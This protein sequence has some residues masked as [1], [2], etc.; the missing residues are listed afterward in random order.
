MLTDVCNTILKQQSSAILKRDKESSYQLVKENNFFKKIIT[1]QIFDL[2]KS[3][4]TLNIS[5][6]SRKKQIIC[7]K[8]VLSF[9]FHLKIREFE[10][11]IKFTV[12]YLLFIGRYMYSLL[13]M[14]ER[15]KSYKP[16]SCGIHDTKT[17]SEVT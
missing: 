5:C 9:R 1:L 2:T 7:D 15:N 4:L 14:Q 13:Q 11:Y 3:C 17:L 6:Y 12:A 10:S 16:N 8:L